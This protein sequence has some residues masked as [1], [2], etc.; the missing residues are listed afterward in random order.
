M[1]T[2]RGHHL[3]YISAKLLIIKTFKADIS[4]TWT[5]PSIN[6][7]E[8]ISFKKQVVI[9]SR[10]R[11]FKS[12]SL[13]SLYSLFIRIPIPTWHLE[14]WHFRIMCTLQRIYKFWMH[15]VIRTA[16]CECFLLSI[17][18]NQNGSKFLQSVHYC[19]LYKSTT[20]SL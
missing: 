13:F 11:Q 15:F 17:I 19:I 10:V 18:W 16:C 20:D 7:Y 12:P 14:I 1:L 9:R 5:R 4:I 3:Q 8:K 2:A 6:W